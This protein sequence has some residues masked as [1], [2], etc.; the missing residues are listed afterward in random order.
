[1]SGLPLGLECRL[2]LWV[3]VWDWDYG[4]GWGRIEKFVPNF[5]CPMNSFVQSREIIGTCMGHLFSSCKFPTS[6]PVE[7]S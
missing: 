3:R 6:V 7:N 1:M 5:H 2:G 4:L